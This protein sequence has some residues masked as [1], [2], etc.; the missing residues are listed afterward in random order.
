ML[1]DKYKE[2]LDGFS[3]LR[4]AVVGDIMVDRFLWGRC[5][6]IS[7]EAP[8]PVV[9]VQRENLKLGGAANVAANLRALGVEAGLVGVCGEDATGASLKDMLTELGLATEGLFCMH[10]RPT[11]LK[12]RLIAQNQQIVRADMEDDRPLT[13]D[14]TERVMQRLLAMGPFSGIVI[15]DY[16]KGLLTDSLLAAVIDQARLEGGVVVVDPKKGDFSQYCGVTSLTPN[17]REAEQA[18]AMT[19]T[20]ESSLTRAGRMLRERTHADCVLITRGEHGMSLFERNGAAHHLPTEATEVYDVTGA[21]DTVIAVY[22]AALAAGGSFREAAGLAN[23]A[24]GLAVREVGTV[25]VTRGQ[26]M[27]ACDGEGRE[28]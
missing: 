1:S 4:L 7:P 22:T 10:D 25:A 28:G 18:C 21:G 13:A 8:V 15:S 5:D 20:D 17:Q 6:R 24:A 19:I 3:R 27:A 9:R 2:I 16:G 12:T 26:L 11:T 14:Q 23:H